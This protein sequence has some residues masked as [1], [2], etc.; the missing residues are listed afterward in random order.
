MQHPLAI[1]IGLATLV[2]VVDVAMT[3]FNGRLDGLYL[4]LVVVFRAARK[5]NRSQALAL[6][7]VAAVF[8]LLPLAAG[9]AE[10]PVE[11][12]FNRGMVVIVL[13]GLLGLPGLREPSQAKADPPVRPSFAPAPAAIP[14][15]PR[16]SR[17]PPRASPPV[18]KPKT[19]RE[20][21]EFARFKVGATV[22]VAPFSGGKRLNQG[23]FR[24]FA[25]HD[26]SQNG[27][28]FWAPEILTWNLI[29]IAFLSRG[30]RIFRVAEITRRRAERGAYLYG[31]QFTDRKCPQIIDDPDM[32]LL[33]QAP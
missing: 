5:L 32:E 16:S 20:R 7:L 22:Q 31:C 23:R 4:L 28:A 27:L 9:V 12:W 26:L 19:G 10:Q 24:E 3:G 8:T 29:V 30:E 2:M 6:T 17:R 13:V 18:E 21:R 1:A 11:A 15:T 33:Q 25:C 14:P